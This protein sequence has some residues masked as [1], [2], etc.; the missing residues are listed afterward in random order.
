MKLYQ[1]TV[2]HGRGQPPVHL[3]WQRSKTKQHAVSCDACEGWQH[4]L[5][6]TG[7]SSTQRKNHS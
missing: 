3:M 5:C 4:R 2:N 1:T 7:A 6:N